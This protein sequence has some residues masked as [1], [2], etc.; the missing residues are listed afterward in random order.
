MNQQ[1]MANEIR[2]YWKQWLPSKY[3]SLKRDGVLE[4]QIQSLAQTAAKE[5]QDSLSSGIPPEEARERVLQELVYV[6]PEAR[7][8]G[9]SE[10]QESDLAQIE[11]NERYVRTGSRLPSPEEADL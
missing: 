7:E 5:Y 4:E 2:K 10:E 11:A 3:R 1:E 8:T 9:M 6:P